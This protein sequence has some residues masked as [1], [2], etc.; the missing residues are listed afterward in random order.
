MPPGVPHEPRP[1]RRADAS[2]CVRQAAD[3]EAASWHKAAGGL[4]GWAGAADLRSIPWR[5]SQSARRWFDRL[6]GV[7]APAGGERGFLEE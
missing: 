2:R 5:P 6:H 7:A 3:R 1:A 4:N